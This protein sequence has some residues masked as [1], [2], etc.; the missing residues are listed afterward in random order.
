MWL[1]KGDGNGA[2]GRG[3]G[4][5]RGRRRG[6]LTKVDIRIEFIYFSW[7]SDLFNR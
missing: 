3:R 2:R 1:G 7:H 5:G 6:D 4:R